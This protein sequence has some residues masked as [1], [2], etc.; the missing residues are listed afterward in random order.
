MAG[1]CTDILQGPYSIFS[2]QNYIQRRAGE[3]KKFPRC[4][5]WGVL[6]T[7]VC[8]GHPLEKF[9]VSPF[10]DYKSL[11][12]LLVETTKVCSVC[13]FSLQKF[14]VSAFCHYKSVECPLFETKKVCRARAFSLQ[15]FVVS[16]F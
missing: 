3:A 9:V 7:Y 15:K 4:T 16:A 14:V 5:F 13:S 2:L 12:C 6:F 1:V 11:K 10:L 8:L